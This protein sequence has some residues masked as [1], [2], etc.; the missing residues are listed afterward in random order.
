MSASTSRRS[1]TRSSGSKYAP[2]LYAEVD[3]D[4]DMTEDDKRIEAAKVLQQKRPKPLNQVSQGDNR[5]DDSSDD[6]LYKVGEL[7]DCRMVYWG[8]FFC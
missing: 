5:I 2:S 1:S 7:L 3:S 4:V 8:P 6:D